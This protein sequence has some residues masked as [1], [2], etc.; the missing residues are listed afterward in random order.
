MDKERPKLEAEVTAAAGRTAALDQLDGTVV[1]LTLA[2]GVSAVHVTLQ[3]AIHQ[4]P[5]SAK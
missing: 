4:D 3:N 1:L 2:N 5:D